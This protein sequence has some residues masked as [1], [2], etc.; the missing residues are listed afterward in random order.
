MKN[1]DDENSKKQEIIFTILTNNIF[2]EKMLD[3]TT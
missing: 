2:T 3:N 1:K